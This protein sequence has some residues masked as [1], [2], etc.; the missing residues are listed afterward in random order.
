MTMCA[1]TLVWYILSVSHGSYVW[2]VSINLLWAFITTVFLAALIKIKK[3]ITS[4][5]VN[6]RLQPNH[7]LMNVNLA[8]FVIS[9][10]FSTNMFVLSLVYTKNDED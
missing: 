7:T 10:I 6:E 9:S 2:R 1:I 5:N 3:L 4:V 8:A